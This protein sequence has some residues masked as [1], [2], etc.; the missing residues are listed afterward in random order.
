[1]ADVKKEAILLTQKVFHLSTKLPKLIFGNR[2]QTKKAGHH[3]S[4]KT[5]EKCLD[6]DRHY[7][8]VYQPAN[9]QKAWL[10]AF[11]EPLHEFGALGAT[12]N[13]SKKVGTGGKRPF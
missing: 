4:C 7:R 5:L 10:A 13:L 1:M 12:I 11:Y 8:L 3:I 9:C 2:S 6:Y